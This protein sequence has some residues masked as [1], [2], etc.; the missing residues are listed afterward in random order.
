MS[1]R[2]SR[3][4]EQLQRRQV[5]NPPASPTPQASPALPVDVF[6][7][8]LMHSDINTI[9]KLCIENPE[10]RH[11]CKDRE[12]WKV[13]Y[14]DFTQK[15]GLPEL[16]PEPGQNVDW[17]GR[18]KDMLPNYNFKTVFHLVKFDFLTSLFGPKYYT[19]TILHSIHADSLRTLESCVYKAISDKIEP[20]TSTFGKLYIEAFKTPNLNTLQSQEAYYT[21]YPY[22]IMSCPYIH[23]MPGSKKVGTLIRFDIGKRKTDAIISVDQTDNFSI[24]DI[25]IQLFNRTNRDLILTQYPQLK[26]LFTDIENRLQGRKLTPYLIGEFV[27]SYGNLGPG[28]SYRTVFNTIDNCPIKSEYEQFQRQLQTQPQY[29]PI[30][31]QQYASASHRSFLFGQ[32]NTNLQQKQTLKHAFGPLTPLQLFKSPSSNVDKQ[33]IISAFN[34]RIEPTYSNLIN[35]ITKSISPSKTYMDFAKTSNIPSPFTRMLQNKMAPSHL[36][37]ILE[38]G[39]ISSVEEFNSIPVQLPNSGRQYMFYDV[40]LI[41]LNPESD[42]AFILFSQREKDPKPVLAVSGNKTQFLTVVLNLLKGFDSSFDIINSISP[43]LNTYLSTLKYEMIMAGYE[44]QTLNELELI[45]NEFSKR[46]NKT[47][48]IRD[49]KLTRCSELKDL[50]IQNRSPRPNTVGFPS[51]WNLPPPS[52]E[53]L[54]RFEDVSRRPITPPRLPN[55]SLPYAPNSPFVRR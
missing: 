45:F 10:L 34:S 13:K 15:Y 40:S 52:P 16:K 38:T 20:F 48:I 5:Q 17:Q 21:K 14:H 8:I 2:I 44:P 46:A 19:P 31:L 4:F 39:I 29:N 33:C 27:L 41:D 49:V 26:L 47:F 3:S 28:T 32:L 12:L 25:I 37:K 24:V 43:T 54:Q 22:Q 9:R 55:R 23:N 53:L 1:Q 36:N 11:I 6:K 30:K 18:L 35:H 51:R 42:R 7:D 50:N